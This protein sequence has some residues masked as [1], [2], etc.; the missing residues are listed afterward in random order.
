M[1]NGKDKIDLLAENDEETKKLRHAF[2]EDVSELMS[3]LE[4]DT[5]SFPTDETAYTNNVVAVTLM[6]VKTHMMEDDLGICSSLNAT[7][8][9][10]PHLHHQRHYYTNIVTIN[11][12]QI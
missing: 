3:D 11:L 6:D 1:I 4:L 9:L 12:K 2:I 8:L 7:I 5:L 10:L